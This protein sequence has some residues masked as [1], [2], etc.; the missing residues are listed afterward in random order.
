VAALLRVEEYGPV[1]FFRLTRTR[2]SR[3]LYWAGAYLVDG[4]LL[5][6]GPPATS[7]ELLRALEG[8]RVEGLAITHHH[9]DHMGAAPLLAS[10]RGLL[11]RIHAAGVPLLREGFRQELYRR[12]V[13][14][15]P[16]RVAAEPLGAEV[17]GRSV[18]L[19]VVATPGHSVDHVC[20]FAPEEGWLF[21]GD[22]FLA[23]RL[24]YLRSDE[25]LS[26]LIRSLQAVARLPLRSVF[27]AHRGLV[28]DGPAALRRKAEHLS[29]MRERIRELLARGLAEREVARQAVGA[30][31]P[32][33]WYS[34][35]RFSAL[36][37]VRAVKRE[38]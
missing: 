6:C 28:P 37:F 18:V 5:D 14:G 8:R 26:S 10:R 3:P 23:E 35:G 15:R 2:F 38:G 7:R 32:M 25:E 27:C 30:E 36:N 20:F 9:E 13:W 11:P 1:V 34:L 19:E 17:R 16:A 21:T 31:G 24:R 29:A 33:T 12:M 22:L 4:L